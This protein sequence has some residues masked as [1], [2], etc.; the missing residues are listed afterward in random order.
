[1]DTRMQAAATW[2]VANCCPVQVGETVLVPPMMRV[3]N[4]PSRFQVTSVHISCHHDTNQIYWC[5]AGKGQVIRLPFGEPVD[6][7]QVVVDNPDAKEA[8]ELF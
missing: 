7:D 4:N 8:A 3:A 6:R 2:M 5:L 1:M